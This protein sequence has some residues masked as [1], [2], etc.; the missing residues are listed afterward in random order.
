MPLFLTLRYTFLAQSLSFAY[1]QPSFVNI[2]TFSIINDLVYQSQYPLTIVNDSKGV[3]DV[4][5]MRDEINASIQRG[6]VVE[7]VPKGDELLPPP[8][9]HY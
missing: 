7:V 1:V 6:H 8:H 4:P 3:L 9:E 5:T 2:L